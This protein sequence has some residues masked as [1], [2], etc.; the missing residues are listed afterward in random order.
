MELAHLFELVVATF[1]VIIVLHW[2][3]HRVGLP[4]PVALI[5]GGALLAFLPNLPTITVDPALVIVVFLPP[6][7]F[8]SAWGVATGQMK[9]HLVGIGSLAV[10]AV[11]FTTV[12]VA[13]ATHLLFPDLPIAACAALGAI[14]SPPDAVSARAVL[15]RVRLP[16][17]IKVLLEGE[18]LLNDASGLVLFR[19]ALAAVAS[20][21]FSAPSAVAEFA[22]LAVGGGLVGAAVGMTWVK[23]VRRL[24]DEYLIIATTTL[25]SWCS[26]ILAEAV[27]VSGVIATVTTGMIASWHA[28]TALTAST[29]M[30]G[31]SFWT[32]TVFLMEAAVFM[33][34]GLSLRGV[35][36]RAGGFGV[37]LQT[38]GL[39][40]LVVLLVLFVSRFVWMFGSD[41]VIAAAHAA[42]LRR[43]TP[44]GARA[45]TVLSWAGVRG[46]VT[47]ALALSV[48]EAFPGRDF[49]LVAAFVVILGTVLVQATTFERV[50]GWAKLAETPGEAARMSMSQ[51]ESAIAQ[52][53]VVV[54]RAAAYDVDGKLIHPQLLEQYERRARGSASY[55]EHPEELTPVLH[56]HFDV[57]LASIA[58]GRGELVRLH[59]AGEIDDETLHELERDLDLAE[60][61]AVSAKNTPT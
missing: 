28:H 8:D 29:R 52:V 17:R 47:L 20:G 36:E 50:I 14:V 41:G 49:I 19:F 18:S 16:R 57:V 12:V 34:I 2:V 33:L 4:A 26:Y 51:V 22:V 48:P 54:V 11:V 61:S 37:V 21:S 59:R 1:L 10:G 15:Q 35:V 42:G 40:S 31:L 53:Q 46:V 9:R 23:L 30:R 7:L 25:L 5:V 44:L 38:M 13:V 27:H 39:P 45:S 3:A 24:D 43:H 55:A 60:L 56:A 32:V 6:L 58:A